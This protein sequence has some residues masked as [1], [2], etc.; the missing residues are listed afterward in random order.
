MARHTS[1]I[2]A[3]RNRETGTTI[4]VHDLDAPDAPLD[5]GEDRGYGVG[6][7][8]PRWLTL[9][10]DHGHLCTHYTRADA[11]S[12]AALPSGWCEPCRHGEPAD[13][14]CET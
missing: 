8:E 2:Q 5:R 9:C 11:I 4:E 13:P 7:D 10:V 3:R 14:E 12:H 6:R 1:L